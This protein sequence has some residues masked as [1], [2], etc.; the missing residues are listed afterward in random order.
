M[1]FRGFEGRLLTSTAL[2]VSLVAGGGGCQVKTTSNTP[3]STPTKNNATATAEGAGGS[4]AE[5]DK[6]RMPSATEKVAVSEKESETIS[7]E[8]SSTVYP[9]CQQFAVEF[10]K[11]NKHKVSVGRQGTGGGYKKFVIRQADIWNAS[12]PI[13]KKE[14][15]ELKS[16]GIEWLELTIA[17]DGIVVAVNS[18][19]SW[20][21]RLTCAQLKRIWEPDS[22]VKTWSHLDS[23]WPAEEIVLFGA[24]TD[25]GTFEYF[26]EVINDK[27]NVIKTKYTPSSDD[28]VL[29]QGISTNKNALGF[30]P[31]GYYIENSEKLNA[32]GI[33]PSKDASETPKPYV[34]PTVESILS[35]EYAP[36]ARPLYMYAN[37]APMLERPEVAEFLRFA[38]SEEA[39]SLVEKRGFVPVTDAVRRQM[40]KRLEEALG[41]KPDAK[42][43]D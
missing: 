36:L 38:V 12:R 43:N 25:S 42:K 40:S 5:T 4:V 37:K 1:V 6:S 27:K 3:S 8:G 11:K 24:D 2:L 22:K 7:V 9:I 35:G 26:T 32:L 17:V 14:I 34:E 41:E 39:Q 23:S 16:K 15:D 10:E 18:Q 13:D 28:N 20:C 31:F 21:S 19:N 33:S 29:V 30:I